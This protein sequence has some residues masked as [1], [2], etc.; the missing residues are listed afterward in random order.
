MVCFIAMCLR[1]VHSLHLHFVQAFRSFR[2]A[3]FSSLSFTPFRLR[4]FHSPQHRTAKAIPSLHFA[5]LSHRLSV[6]W[7]L[8]TQRYIVFC[9]EIIY[10]KPPQHKAN[11]SCHYKPPYAFVPFRSVIAFALNP[12]HV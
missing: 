3:S 4:S 1:S 8:L 5:N 10:K 12:P 11:C 7:H 9:D 2:F 6:S